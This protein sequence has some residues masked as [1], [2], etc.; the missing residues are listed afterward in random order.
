MSQLLPCPHCSRHHRACEPLCPFCGNP[1]PPCEPA[2]QARARG[3]LNRA[4]LFA[5]G[6]ALIGGATCESSAV[7]L[8][9]APANVTQ[10]DAGNDGSIEAP[11]DAAMIGSGQVLYGGPVVAF[12]PDATAD[13]PDAADG[14]SE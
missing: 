5:A 8:Y 2:P 4:T 14:G 3:R 6:A 9:G 10:P 7:P 1:L 11:G 13:T 12:T